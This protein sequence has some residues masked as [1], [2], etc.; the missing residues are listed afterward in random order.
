[1]S[2]KESGKRL[3]DWIASKGWTK[4]EFARRMEIL[5]QTV[6]KYVNGDVSVDNL[7]VKL[8]REGADMHWI[9]TGEKSEAGADAAMLAILKH[10]GITSPEQLTAFM[11][12]TARAK[13]LTT[14]AQQELQLLGTL[15]EL[16]GTTRMKVLKTVPE[17]DETLPAERNAK[18]V[19]P[20]TRSE[21]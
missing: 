10:S 9:L 7:A 18:S 16:G 21:L 12:A 5:P 14:M 19:K 15:Q 17:P 2:E 11:D 3:A 13:E 6:T 4:A 20:I 8:L 1:M